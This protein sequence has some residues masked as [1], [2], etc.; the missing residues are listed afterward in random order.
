MDFLFW[1]PFAPR[2]R[3]PLFRGWRC[4][5]GGVGG[6]GGAKRLCEFLVLLVD[7]F[8]YMDPRTHRGGAG[9]EPWAPSAVPPPLWA[10]ASED[11]AVFLLGKLF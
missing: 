10:L 3:V 6:E 8:L 2:T 1:T 11:L 9:S 7:F 5:D 4:V